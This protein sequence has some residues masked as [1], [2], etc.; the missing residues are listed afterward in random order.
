MTVMP[1]QPAAPASPVTAKPELKEQA[2]SGREA[3]KLPAVE[4]RQHRNNRK[5]PGKFCIQIASTQVQK[6]AEALKAKLVKKGLPVYVT[7]SAIKDRGTW[8]RVRAGSTFLSR[9]RANWR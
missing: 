1:L 2:K 6:E 7:E 8:F 5:P 4:P 9:Q 3:K